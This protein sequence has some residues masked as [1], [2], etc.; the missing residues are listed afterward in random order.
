MKAEKDLGY[1]AG[2]CVVGPVSVGKTSIIRRVEAEVRGGVPDN[3]QP[4]LMAELTKLQLSAGG[5]RSLW[6]TITDTPGMKRLFH[7]LP[8]NILRNQC[9]YLIVFDLT[10]RDTFNDIREWFQPISEVAP[11]FAEIVLVG[12]KV[13]RDEAERKV[14]RAEA[15][16]VAKLMNA[17]YIETSSKTG[18][19]IM[20]LFEGIAH[21][22]SKK[23]EFGTL[24]IDDPLNGIRVE[25]KPRR[26]SNVK[27]YK[28]ATPS[29]GCCT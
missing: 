21:N 7:A 25:S 10:D 11:N 5:G 6:L 20:S 15:E 26:A 12:N 9:A 22:I 17:R 2:V 27:T 29:G 28:K 16:E 13:D 24:R 1:S 14:S 23:V 4:S 8:A 18:Q 19:N 3:V